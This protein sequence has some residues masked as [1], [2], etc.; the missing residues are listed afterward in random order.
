MSQSHGPL[1]PHGSLKTDLPLEYW[2]GPSRELHPQTLALKLT[3][4]TLSR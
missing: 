1:K 4:T 2:N 3:N